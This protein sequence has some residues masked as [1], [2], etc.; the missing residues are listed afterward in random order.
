MS[1]SVEKVSLS[2]VGMCSASCYQHGEGTDLSS[3]QEGWTGPLNWRE[4]EDEALLEWCGSQQ[5]QK[6][7]H[8]SPV[9]DEQLKRFLLLKSKIIDTQ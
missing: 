3:L 5:E 8:L 6:S 7:C 1:S 2:C 9:S 4:A